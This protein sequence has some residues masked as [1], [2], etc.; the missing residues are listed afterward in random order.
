MAAQFHVGVKI[1]GEFHCFP[2]AAALIRFFGCEHDVRWSIGN[3]SREGRMAATNRLESPDVDS[4][5]I[6]L[7][8]PG[9]GAGCVEV[10]EWS[11]AWG[12][13]IRG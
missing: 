9:F 11:G 5:E 4:Y 2:A 13:R 12:A 7:R 3:P 1:R 10:F 8:A 6:T